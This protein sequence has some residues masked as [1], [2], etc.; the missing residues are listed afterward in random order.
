M[1][2]SWEVAHED[3]LEWGKKHLI[4]SYPILSYQA[5]YMISLSA[6]I[7][8]PQQVEKDDKQNTRLLNRKNK[9]GCSYKTRGDCMLIGLHNVSHEIKVIWPV[10]ELLWEGRNQS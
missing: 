9:I 6:Y 3:C 5:H 1:P 4:L 10:V 7:Y 2:F 8:T